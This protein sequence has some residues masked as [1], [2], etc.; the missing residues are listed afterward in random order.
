MEASQRIDGGKRGRPDECEEAE[1]FEEGGGGG[2]RVSS[3]R[4]VDY[5]SSNK[6]LRILR[7]KVKYRFF[8]EISRRSMSRLLRLV[9]IFVIS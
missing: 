1:G 2:G 3:W 8:K 6:K 9:A 5:V 4:E 7:P